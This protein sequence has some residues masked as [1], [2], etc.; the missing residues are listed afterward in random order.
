MALSAPIGKGGWY[1][2]IS[3]NLDASIHMTA[4]NRELR[5]T[6]ICIDSVLAVVSVPS[7]I[8]ISPPPVTLASLGTPFDVGG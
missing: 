6:E 4:E 1:T 5:G 3:N 8:S 2:Q 7:T